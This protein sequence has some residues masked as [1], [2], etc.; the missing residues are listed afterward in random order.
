MNWSKGKL[1]VRSLKAKDKVLIKKWLT[2]PKILEFYEGR[3]KPYS[4]DMVNADF[5]D[6]N[7]EIDRS[8]VIYKDSPIGYIQIYPINEQTSA[9]T[10][11]MSKGNVWYGSVHRRG[12]LLE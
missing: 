9:L 1:G 4:L 6:H 2:D 5:Y 10:E 11:Y 8:I 7:P 3:D 12:R